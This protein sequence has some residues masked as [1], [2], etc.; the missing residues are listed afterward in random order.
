MARPKTVSKPQSK[1]NLKKTLST[2]LATTATTVVERRKDE[3]PV[4]N[5]PSSL[6]A[7]AVH[8]GRDLAYIEKLMELQERHYAHQLAMEKKQAER[9]FDQ[10]FARFQGD[11]PMIY[12]SH[13]SGFDH[14]DGKGRTEYKHEKLGDVLEVVKKPMSDNGLTRYW[15]MIDSG[16]EITVTCV[17]RHF[18]GHERAEATLSAPPDTSGYKDV[19]KA[20]SSTISYLERI[21]LK[22]ALGLA[23]MDDDDDGAGSARFP[24]KEFKPDVPFPTDK[25]YRDVM[26]SIAEGKMTLERAEAFYTFSDE[27]R[28]SLRLT[29]ENSHDAGRG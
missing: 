28:E 22:A 25:E 23:A 8:A 16:T 10:A 18:A 13:T 3:V 17:I 21:T 9:D 6:L 1:S 11:C 7:A 12:K 19:I 24:E 27:Q 4:D 20:K 2:D 14:K 15:R 5:S 26:N 29:E